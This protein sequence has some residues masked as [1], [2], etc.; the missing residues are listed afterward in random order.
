MIQPLQNGSN[1]KDF[2]AQC[3]QAVDH[4]F[5]KTL[6]GDYHRWVEQLAVDRGI[7][8]VTLDEDTRR[9]ELVRPYFERLGGQPGLAVISVV[10]SQNVSPSATPS[11][12]TGSIWTGAGWDSITSTCNIRKV[13]ASSCVSAPTFP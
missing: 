2:F 10:A 1:I 11:A 13:A 9:E 3:G 6:S 5:L 7:D 4:K 8:I 12:A